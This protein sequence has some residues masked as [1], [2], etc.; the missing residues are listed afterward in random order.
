MPSGRLVFGMTESW[1]G[2]GVHCF[3][4]LGGYGSLSHQV[5]L[6]GG[7][8]ERETLEMND[9]D[10]DKSLCNAHESVGVIFSA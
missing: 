1:A 2:Q 4:M 7:R 10:S 8:T 3:S 5:K 9:L 6:S